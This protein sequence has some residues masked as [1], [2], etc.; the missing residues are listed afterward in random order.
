[1]AE[2]KFLVRVQGESSMTA[3]VHSSTNLVP[4]EPDTSDKPLRQSYFVMTAIAV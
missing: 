1:M 2:W 3:I 4:I